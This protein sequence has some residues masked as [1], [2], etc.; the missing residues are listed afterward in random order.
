MD[1]MEQPSR[2]GRELKTIPQYFFE[3]CD[4]FPA[5]PAQ[6]FNPSLYNNDH[7][8]TLSWESLRTRVRMIAGGL[9][10][11]GLDRQEKAAI[12]SHSSPFWTQ[13]DLAL[14]CVNAVSVPIYPFTSRD[15]VRRLINDTECRCVLAGNGDIVKTIISLWDE[16]PFLRKIVLLDLRAKSADERVI[17]LSELLPLGDEWLKDNR[18]VFEARWKGV[19]PDDVYSIIHTPGTGGSAKGVIVT[20]GNASLR[21]EDAVEHLEESDMGITEHDR[22]LCHLP[23]SHPFERVSCQLLAVRKGACINYADRPGTLF[24]ETRKYNPTWINTTPDTLKKTY[25]HFQQAMTS[26]FLKKRIFQ[27]S[28]RLGVQVL[29]YRR[30]DTGCYD[31]SMDIDPRSML[32]WGMKIRFRIAGRVLAKL[33]SLW[34]HGLRYAICGLSSLSPDLLRIHLAAGIAITEGY[35]STE[36]FGLCALNPVFACKPGHAGQEAFGTRARISE[37]GEIELAHQG[38]FSGYFNNSLMQ[39]SSFTNDGWY[40]TGDYGMVSDDGYL[41]ITGSDNDRLRMSSGNMVFA[42]QIEDLFATSPAI[43]QIFISGDNSECITALIVPDF[44]HF[45]KMFEAQGVRYNK[46]RLRWDNSSGVNVCC[47]VGEDFI[48]AQ[49]LQETI[50]QEVA[51]ANSRVEEFAQIRHYTVLNERFSESNGRLTATGK[52]KY[53]AVQEAFRDVVDKM[54]R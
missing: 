9:I 26:N 49:L 8:G 6:R 21:I 22:T 29:E 3:T 47:C 4:T 31:M 10:A 35:C 41:A 24:E 7:G 32:P 15:E 20:H 16:T 14:A 39:A 43:E 27:W 23:L 25:V 54:N 18:A 34:G 28:L 30:D 19:K 50:R 37:S 38:L 1:T 5:R 36:S 42:R 52:I 33:H 17:C 11:L 45:I 51:S 48:S 13:A 2:A 53:R 44:N 40:K 46:N 12:M